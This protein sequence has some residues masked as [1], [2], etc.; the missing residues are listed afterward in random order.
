MLRLFKKGPF[1]NCR[2]GS[3]GTGDKKNKKM[4]LVQRVL[5]PLP[6][7]LQVM[8]REAE[9]GF[10][11]SLNGGFT[12]GVGG[13]RNNLEWMEKEEGTPPPQRSFA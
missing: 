10:S 9:E 3:G 13:G 8:V 12:R 7:L 5:V 1:G 11:R 4:G 2:E 6:S